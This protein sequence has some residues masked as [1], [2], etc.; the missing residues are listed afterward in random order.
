[1]GAAKAPNRTAA[2]RAGCGG[3]GTGLRGNPRS[4]TPAV[5]ARSGAATRR[6]FRGARSAGTKG[7]RAG[8]AI[9]ARRGGWRR[10][11]MAGRVAAAGAGATPISGAASQ[12]TVNSAVRAADGAGRAPLKHQASANHNPACAATLTAKLLRRRRRCAAVTV[13]T[14]KRG[15]AARPPAARAPLKAPPDGARSWAAGITCPQTDA[16]A[17][18]EVDP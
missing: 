12:V 9:A 3:R 15:A 6:R 5:V 4:T 14:P 1:M 2:S 8:G 17:L 7:A 11:G 13:S 16:A 10:R 18:V